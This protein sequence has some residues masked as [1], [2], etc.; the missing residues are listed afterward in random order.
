MKISQLLDIKPGLTA[1]IGGGGKTT[2]MYTLARELSET[3]AVIICTSTKIYEPDDIAV[4]TDNSVEEIK[5]ALERHRVVCT[6]TRAGEGK[7][8]A[9]A[10]G[11]DELKS[12]A[13]YVIAEADGA[14]RLPIKAHA[15]YE[16]VIPDGTDKT[17]LVIG[18]DCFGRP[19]SDI[20][21][22][23]E[24]FADIAGVGIS[25]VITP[26]IVSRVIKREGLGDCLYINKVGDG[27]TLQY[28]RQLARLL[29][30][31]VYAGDLK[32]GEYLCLR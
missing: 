18:A 27:K 5:A 23:P 3:G 10:V 26:D 16:P 24:L 19:I 20:A 8:S 13:D 31:P 6:G 21:H 22:R 12:L 1:L 32:K 2:L 25:S 15:D 28:A 17:I 14:H 7:L 11:F 9:P 4:V 30:M 29:D